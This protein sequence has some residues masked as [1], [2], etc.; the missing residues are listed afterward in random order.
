MGGGAHTPTHRAHTHTRIQAGARISE[1]E[2]SKT[3][4]K[5]TRQAK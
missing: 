4:N 1:Q 5:R 2:P 3:T